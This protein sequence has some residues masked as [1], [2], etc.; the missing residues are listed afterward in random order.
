MQ[1]SG[2][3]WLGSRLFYCFFRGVRLEKGEKIALASPLR[4]RIILEARAES[5]YIW[6]LYEQKLGLQ[7]GTK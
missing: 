1:D 6:K 2:L 4:W 5:G 3:K 7:K